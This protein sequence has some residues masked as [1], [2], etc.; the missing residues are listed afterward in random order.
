[1]AGRLRGRVQRDAAIGLE[2]DPRAVADRT[3]TAGRLHEQRAAD[4][5]QAPARGR[6]GAARREPGPVAA[7]AA[8][9]S[10]AA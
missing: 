7:R 3:P 10:I 5:A 8:R 2:R 1:L 9:S 4:A 6:L